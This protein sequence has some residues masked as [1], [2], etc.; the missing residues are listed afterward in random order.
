MLAPT[1]DRSVFKIFSFPIPL[2]SLNVFFPKSILPPSNSSRSN[3]TSGFGDLWKLHLELGPIFLLCLA[4]VV[5]ITGNSLFCATLSEYEDFWSF[6]YG[7]SR[8]KCFSF[9]HI[10]HSLVLGLNLPWDVDLKSFLFDIFLPWLLNL[11]SVVLVETTNPSTLDLGC[12]P[13]PFSLSSCRSS[14]FFDY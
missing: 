14:H 9:P 10:Q 7:H 5:R 12:L 3:S 2:A 11:F 4:L 6:L 8:L 1:L 13:N